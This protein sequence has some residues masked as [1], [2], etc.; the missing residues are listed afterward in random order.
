MGPLSLLVLA[1]FVFTVVQG[2]VMVWRG[3]SILRLLGL[4]AGMAATA[5]FVVLWLS[6]VRVLI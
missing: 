1:C 5:F 2:I 6:W 3:Y 4:I